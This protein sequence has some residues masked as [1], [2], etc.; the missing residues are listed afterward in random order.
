MLIYKFHIGTYPCCKIQSWCDKCS[1]NPTTSNLKKLMSSSHLSLLVYY[2]LTLIISTS[3]SLGALYTPFEASLHLHMA[4]YSQD[5]CMWM[6]GFWCLILKTLLPTSDSSCLKITL[7]FYT[8]DVLLV[9]LN[10]LPQLVAV[11]C[12]LSA[13]SQGKLRSWSCNLFLP[14]HLI[15]AC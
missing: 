10:F 15:C 3:F 12:S 1:M 6:K 8:K 9:M 2:Y 4:Q 13:Y 14:I 5:I 7:S 11:I